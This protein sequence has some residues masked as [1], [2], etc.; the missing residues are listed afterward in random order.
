M[1]MPI[2]TNA[3]PNGVSSAK[4]NFPIRA[5]KPDGVSLLLWCDVVVMLSS[6]TLC[7]SRMGTPAR[8]HSIQDGQDT[9]PP[10]TQFAE[11]DE[12]SDIGRTMNIGA[13]FWDS[14]WSRGLSEIVKLV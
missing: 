13:L 12:V 6:L 3:K 2:R 11:G 8:H 10:E 1:Q 7:V 5:R 9:R 14:R 4:K